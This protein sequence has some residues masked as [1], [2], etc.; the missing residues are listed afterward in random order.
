[1]NLD[2][3]LNRSIVRAALSVLVIA[4]GGANLPGAESEP[5]TL[6]DMTAYQVEPSADD[7]AEI[8]LGLEAVDREIGRLHAVNEKRR[9]AA[10]EETDQK[11]KNIRVL[12]TALAEKFTKEAWDTLLLAVFSAMEANRLA[13]I[14]L[15]DASL[16]NLSRNS[17]FL[18]AGKATVAELCVPCHL[19]SLKGQSAAGFGPDLTDTIWLHGGRPSEIY[20]FITHGAFDRGMPPWGSIIGAKK[21]VEVTA[22]VLSKHSEGEPIHEYGIVLPAAT[23]SE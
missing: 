3:L 8:K 12:R 20:H 22:Y 14:Q 16:W 13:A 7:P 6:V 10:R 4:I 18:A 15:D 5:A 23:V 2:Y 11:L 1:M 19:P 9:G 17:A 21:V